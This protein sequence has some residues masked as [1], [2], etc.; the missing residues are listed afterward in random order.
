MMT[1][2]EDVTEVEGWCR[3]WSGRTDCNWGVD[4]PIITV[5]M[6][7]TYIMLSIK[8][9]RTMVRMDKGSEVGRKG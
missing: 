2:A 3:G 8:E 5:S 4:S 9:E 1:S 7:C 6:G